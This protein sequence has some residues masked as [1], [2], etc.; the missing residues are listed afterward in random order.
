MATKLN[1]SIEIVALAV[2]W[3]AAE[4]KVDIGDASE[5]ISESL[6]FGIETLGRGVCRRM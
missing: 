5:L 3:L 2:G 1:M 4:D 6:D